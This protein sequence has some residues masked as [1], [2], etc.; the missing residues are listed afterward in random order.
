MPGK[1]DGAR[2]T[3]AVAVSV[4]A[5]AALGFAAAWQLQDDGTDRNTTGGY[6]PAS[7]ETGTATVVQRPITSVMSL[8]GTVVANPEFDA[9][10]PVA[11]K[12]TAVRGLTG[13]VKA[14]TVLGWVKPDGKAVPVTTPVAATVGDTLV[15]DGASVP[16]GLPLTHLKTTGFGIRGTVSGVLK[17]RLYTLATDATAQ[18]EKGPGPFSCPVLGGPV[19][20]T[21][22]DGE[23]A[24]AADLTVTC[25]APKKLRLFP[26]LTAQVA[27]KTGQVKNALAV[28]VGA[29]AGSAETGRVAVRLAGGNLEVRD[30]TLGINDGSFVQITK[31]LVAGDVVSLQP[32]ALT[33]A[34]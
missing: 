13:I 9:V 34:G 20:G 8:A 5:A 33:D 3:L 19:S 17:Y 15:V 27:I 22:D 10:A 16:A 30:V 18:I 28:P 11:G 23:A 31:G 24:G 6:S 2:R 7:A 21:G 29:V 1:P 14:G 4:L 12:F 32:P 25:A 26:G